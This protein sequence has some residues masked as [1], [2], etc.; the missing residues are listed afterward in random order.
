[1]GAEREKTVKR[2]LITVLFC[3]ATLALPSLCH[4]DF[5]LQF[6]D[7]SETLEVITPTGTRSCLSEHCGLTNT[8]G[9][10]T[11]GIDLFFNIYDQDG[12]TLRLSPRLTQMV[13]THLAVR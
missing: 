6:L 4:A 5:V 7:S 12:V 13:K 11:P 9:F 8:F 2:T 1:M 10:P 3:V